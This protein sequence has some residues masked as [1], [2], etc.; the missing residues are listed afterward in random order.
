MKCSVGRKEGVGPRSHLGQVVDTAGRAL[1]G[2]H[3]SC[4]WTRP[5]APVPRSR[6]WSARNTGLVSGR[7]L[8]GSDTRH[9]T[10]HDTA[11]VV[12][13]SVAPWPKRAECREV[14]ARGS[15]E[16]CKLGRPTE[17][18]NPPDK[19][20]S[21]K[22]GDPAGQPGPWSDGCASVFVETL[23]PRPKKGAGRSAETA[24]QEP[25]RSTEQPDQRPWSRSRVPGASGPRSSPRRRLVQSSRTDRPVAAHRQTRLWAIQSGRRSA[26]PKN[27]VFRT[28]RRWRARQCEVKNA[29]Q[30]G[31][32]C[33]RIQ[34]NHSGRL[35]C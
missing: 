12:W 17:V 24:S 30:S 31:V 22:G 6:T 20:R 16:Y 11:G 23:E 7:R 10:A 2:V 15:R 14:P 1:E 26:W 9:G 28:Y 29:M 32:T 5:T 33:A 13:A 27:G 18:N 35:R 4:S 21:R 25:C 19:S 3:Q 8:R 34:V